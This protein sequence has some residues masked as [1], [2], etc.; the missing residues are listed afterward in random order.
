MGYKKD[1]KSG[2]PT[3]VALEKIPG[4][5]YWKENAAKLAKWKTW[6]ATFDGAT[7]PSGPGFGYGFCG[8]KGLL[9]ACAKAPATQ[10]TIDMSKPGYPPETCITDGDHKPCKQLSL[11]FKGATLMLEQIRT[12]VNE[13]CA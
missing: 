4:V 7:G 2:L 12:L 13:K 6:D 3:K 8:F 1:P 9:K 10:Y 5:T 11:P